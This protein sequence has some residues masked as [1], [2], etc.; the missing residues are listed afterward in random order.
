[1]LLFL[2][3]GTALPLSQQQNPA[4]EII[5]PV[6]AVHEQHFN[7]LPVLV[8]AAA[9]PPQEMSRSHHGAQ[10]REGSITGQLSA[11]AT[12]ERPGTV[13]DH[14]PAVSLMVIADPQAKAILPPGELLRLRQPVAP[15]EQ[16]SVLPPQRY[17]QRSPSGQGETLL[18][19]APLQFR[20]APSDKKIPLPVRCGRGILFCC[21]QSSERIRAERLRASALTFSS[22]MRVST[23]SR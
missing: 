2:Q 11:I 22:S 4:E 12:P 19:Q 6:Q 23:P 21:N 9:E 13:P 14:L 17:S 8:P 15:G 20:R 3:M 10:C 5:L 1:M 16:G 7:A 18:F